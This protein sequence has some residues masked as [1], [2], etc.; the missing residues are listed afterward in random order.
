MS[1]GKGNI[2]DTAGL[3]D[4]NAGVN[5]TITASQAP[6][7]LCELIHGTH[8]LASGRSYCHPL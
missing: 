4:N 8:T 7:C 3:R 6:K 1:L 2:I 5:D